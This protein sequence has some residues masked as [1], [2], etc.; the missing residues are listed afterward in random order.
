MQ[1]RFTNVD[2]RQV[3]VNLCR[4]RGSLLLPTD[5]KNAVDLQK[6][7]TLSRSHSLPCH[8]FVLPFGTPKPRGQGSAWAEVRSWRK[9]TLPLLRKRRL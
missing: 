5:T 7:K 6:G 8:L 3:A 1:L 4:Q 2:G 9:Q